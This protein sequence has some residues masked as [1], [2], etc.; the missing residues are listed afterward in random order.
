MDLLVLIFFHLLNC[1]LTKLLLPILQ[2]DQTGTIVEILV[3]DG[4][5]VSIDTVYIYM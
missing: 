3:G 2:S 4:K 1:S 5:P